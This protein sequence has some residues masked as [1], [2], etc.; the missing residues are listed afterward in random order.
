MA[1]PSLPLEAKARYSFAV[2]DPQGKSERRQGNRRAF[3]RWLAEIEVRYPFGGETFTAR[4]VE[5]AEAGFTLIT[6]HLLEIDSVIDLDFRFD[7]Q[8]PWVH[9]K[10]VVRHHRNNRVGIEFRNLRIHDRLR[11][12]ERASQAPAL[13]DRRD[14]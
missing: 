2:G 1:L 5:V 4:G 8:E 12:M 11:L 10:A 14:R 6:D 9:V 13:P 3:P 7:P